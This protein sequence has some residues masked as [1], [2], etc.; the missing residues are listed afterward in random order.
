MQQGFSLMSS[1]SVRI[2]YIEYGE[3]RLLGGG[4]LDL[5]VL[6]VSVDGSSLHVT[7]EQHDGIH[8]AECSK[9]ADG[10]SEEREV[11]VLD[12]CEPDRDECHANDQEKEYL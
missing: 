3:G 4:R 8:E 12:L 1:P 6:G 5:A 2:V 10:K 9:S 7:N 11:Q